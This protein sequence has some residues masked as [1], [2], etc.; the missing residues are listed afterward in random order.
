V[1]D[2]F[3]KQTITEI[4]K[5]VGYRCSNPECSRPTVAANAAQ[6]GT[7][8]IGVAAH[9][10]AASPGGPR[11]DPAQTPGDRRDKENG[12]WLCQNCGR[13]IDADPKKFTVDVL[14]KWKHDTQ[15]RAFQ[16]LVGPSKAGPSEEATRISLLVAADATAVTNAEAERVFAKVR[17]A[18]QVDLLTFQTDPMWSTRPVELTLR[19]AENSDAPPFR[20]SNL[21][22]AL[23]IAA[24]ATIVAP[25][26]TGKT[27]TVLQ[28][29]G[30]VITAGNSVPL[31]FRLGDWSAGSSTLLASLHARAAFNGVSAQEVMQ[32]AQRGRVLLLLDGWNELDTDARKKLRLELAQVR[33]DCPHIRIVATTRQQVLDVPTTGP[34]VEIEPLSEDQQMAIRRAI[35]GDDGAKIVDEAWRTPGVRELIA[36]PL[37]LTA[38]VSGGVPTVRPETKEQLLRLFVE[39]H[40][41]VNE[42]AE[43]LQE[44]LHGCHTDVLTALA[45]D[46]NA[47]GLTTMTDAEARRIIS[48]TLNKLVQDQQINER[49]EP[50]KVLELLTSHHTL[51]RGAGGTGPISFQH[52]QFQEWFASRE[53]DELMRLSARG[54][55]SA[56]LRLRAAILDQPAWEESI[57][58]AVERLSREVGGPAVAADAIRVALAVDPMLAAEMIFRVTDET[59]QIV[60]ADIV[61]FA[62]RWH[63][64]GHVDRAIRFMVTTG[65]SDFESYVWPLASNLHSQVQLPTLRSAERFRPAVLGLN[66]D[67]KVAAL[68]EETRRRLLGQIAVESG[69]DGLD[70]ATAIAKKD[71]SP[72]VQ[73][74]VV[75]YLQFRRADRHVADLMSAA[76]N[77]TWALV[78]KRGYADEIT[79]PDISARLQQERTKALGEAATPAQRLNL[80]LEQPADFSGRDAA[81][82]EAIADP[83]YPVRD[84][85][86]GSAIYH[87]QERA[88]ASVLQGLRRRLEAGLDLPFHAEDFLEQLDVTDEGPIATAILDVSDDKGLRNP[89]AVMA[90]PKTVAALVDRYLV[91]TKAARSDRA[92]QSLWDQH[93]RLSGRLAETRAPSL[94][95][96]VIERANTNDVA[97]FMHSPNSFL[98]METM[99]HVSCRFHL[100]QQRSQ[101]S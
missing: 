83:A 1:R 98:G 20:I 99:T 86:G 33:R 49:P 100:M 51:T 30:D 64:T 28:L 3:T 82:A 54:D 22:P 56:R 79:D 36:T 80:L 62:T 9:I 27:T 15:T 50:A 74:E 91:C 46:L 60:N 71:P 87:A 21:P 17:A 40:D 19:L 14:T 37:Y 90:G 84:Q 31:Y 2:D 61:A 97:H 55:T 66:I 75:Q 70:L 4:A 101:S 34:R 26:G 92:N 95:S 68:P 47:R 96:A 53:V 72:T 29:A 73:A 8:T 10:C 85:H 59:W 23:E 41:R 39:Q 44:L 5:G 6:D 7:I 48:T 88:P 32:L 42:H 67:T 11:Y 94:I 63:S 13:L 69:V 81:I 78:A 93:R 65:R 52:Q 58:F 35:A 76:H 16:E 18:A 25:P 43:P 38:L 89:V 12:L 57:Y 24:E 77:E 45:S